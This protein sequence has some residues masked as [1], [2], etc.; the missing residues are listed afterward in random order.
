MTLWSNIIEVSWVWSWVDGRR[1]VRLRD[2]FHTLQGVS[3]LVSRLALKKPL[4]DWNHARKEVSMEGNWNNVAGPELVCGAYKTLQ[5]DFPSNI[6]SSFLH[7]ELWCVFLVVAWSQNDGEHRREIIIIFFSQCT[8]L[9]QT[10]QW[11]KLSTIWK[12]WENFL[13]NLKFP[14]WNSTFF[15]VLWL[16]KFL[17]FLIL[18]R[19]NWM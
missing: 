9:S 11:G 17:A 7:M 14:L 8:S 18:N 10:E 3:T 2:F 15:L 4:K 5:S 12:T 16:F 6:I 13:W 1:A 19:V